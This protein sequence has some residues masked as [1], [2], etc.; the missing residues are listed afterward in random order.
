MAGVRKLSIEI[1]GD[2]KGVSKAFGQAEQDAEGFGKKMGGVA[3]TAGIAFLG[4]GGAAVGA[5]VVLSKWASDAA[6]D[7]AEQ[8]L[9]EKQIK[10]AG[11]TDA[12]IEAFNKQIDA[13]MKLKGFTDTELRDSYAQAFAQSKD[14]ATANADVALAMDIARKAGVPLGTALDAVTKAH[15]GQTTA[16]GKMLPEY[17]ALIKNAGS[18]AE[19]LELVRGATAGMSDEFANTAQGRMERAK[20]QFGELKETVGA[21]FIPVM[22]A[23]IPVV[24]NVMTW[25]GEH[26]PG[27]MAAVKTWVDENWPA[28]RDGIMQAVTAIREGIAG[29]V[30]FV[31]EVWAQW[32]AEITAVATR[33]FGYVQ[34]TVQNALEIVRGI[35]KTVTSIITGDWSAAWEGIKQILSGVWEQIKNLVSLALDGLKLALRLAWEGIKA[36]ASAL[37]DGIKSVISG[38]WDGIKSAVKG[39]VDAVVEYVKGIP[40]KLIGLAAGFATAGGNIASAI[41]DGI[42]D[43]FESLL[44]K[45]TNAAKGFAN[46]IIRF[47]NEKVIRKI[48]DLLEFRI[49][50]PGGVGITIDP[51]DLPYIS[52]FHTGGVVGGMSF[53]GMAPDDV[54]AVL[55][56]GETV[57]T[58]AQLEAVRTG[59]GSSSNRRDDRRREPA[60]RL[61]M[62]GGI[63]VNVQSNADPYAVGSAVAWAVKTSGR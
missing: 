13:G 29:F 48:N 22:E 57:L 52:T 50:G 5:G 60:Q 41:V 16:L 47:V 2:A 28:I 23:I 18:S 44:S 9:M 3:K 21:A 39:A 49:E 8:S 46:A 12:V 26:L 36:T 59:S 24:S 25:L 62:A 27:A 7:A 31:Q 37:W 19:A 30:T 35:I 10:L 55:R 14:M 53:R 51:P 33:V 38:A 11:G 56:K 34:T 6:A 58:P 32:G 61:T 20:M 15:N 17:G 4:I 63:T 42:A 1:L 43:G 45:A 54:A 40:G